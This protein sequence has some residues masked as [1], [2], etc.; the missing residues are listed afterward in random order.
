MSKKSEEKDPDVKPIATNRRAS[1]DYELGTRYEA[2][3]VLI[4]SEVKSLRVGSANLSDAWISLRGGEAF[5]EGLRI[6]VLT[7]AAFGHAES[8]PRKLLLHDREIVELQGEIDRKGMT[9]IATRIYFR[10]GRVKL[11]I[12]VAKGRRQGDKREAIKAKE[13]ER[14]AKAA[15]DLARKGRFR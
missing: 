14:E 2:G 5:V 10:K 15:I 1:F 11:E 7:H 9:V 4:G 8:R 13:A 6:P 12:A 3:L